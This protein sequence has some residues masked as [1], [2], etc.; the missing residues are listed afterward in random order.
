MSSFARLPAILSVVWP[1][2][3]ALRLENKTRNPG[4]YVGRQSKEEHLMDGT[5]RSF[6]KAAVTAAGAAATPDPARAQGD[7]QT[8]GHAHQ[9]GPF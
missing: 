2:I 6:L 4:R 1:W 3:Q 8:D 5:R 9:N 7:G